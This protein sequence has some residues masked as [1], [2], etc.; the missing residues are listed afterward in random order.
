LEYLFHVSLPVRYFSGQTFLLYSPLLSLQNVANSGKVTLSPSHLA[1][2]VCDYV[3]TNPKS[4]AG[5]EVPF[6]VEV[7]L[8]K[9]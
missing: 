9:V 5:T 6:V 8:G 7:W 4:P 2:V 3:D 1:G